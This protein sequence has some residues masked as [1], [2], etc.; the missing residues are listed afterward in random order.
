MLTLVTAGA[1][2]YEAGQ[3]A[4]CNA[5]QALLQIVAWPTNGTKAHVGLY[6]TAAK[7]WQR[8]PVRKPLTS[9]HRPYCRKLRECVCVTAVTSFRGVHMLLRLCSD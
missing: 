4:S 9:M 8:K 3:Q 5:V 7:T 2:R 1:L 6:R